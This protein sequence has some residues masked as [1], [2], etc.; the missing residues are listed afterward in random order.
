MRSRAMKRVD[1]VL[2][3]I[4]GKDVVV[5]LIGESGTGKE[6]LARRTH[7]LSGRRRGPFIP[8]NCAAIPEALFESELFGHERGAFTGARD[9]AKGK[10]EAAEGGT[11]FLDEIGEMPL[12]MQTKLLRFLENRRFMRVGG[13]TKIEAD[14]RLVFATLRPLEQEVRAGRFRADLFYRIQGITLHVPPLRERR[15]DIAPLLVQFVDQLSARHGAPRPRLTRQAKALMLA[16]EWPG[17]VRELRNVVE[18][19]CLL[20]GGRQ[21]RTADL[22]DALRAATRGTPGPGAAT[23]P[24]TL[25]VSLDEGLDAMTARI[26]E[27]ALA[28]EGGHAGKAAARLRISPRTVQRHLAAGRVRT[29]SFPPTED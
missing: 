24:A 11:L 4:A 17:N 6:V 19:L 25:T 3:A 22:P 12:L 29:I 7:E 23:A 18:T 10:V 5:T 28:L 14:V 1:R 13:V 21:V 9:R 27:A 8:I 15:E 16:Y 2:R 20:R 26:V